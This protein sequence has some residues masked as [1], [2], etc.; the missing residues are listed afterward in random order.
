ME[1]LRIC[2]QKTWLIPNLHFGMSHWFLDVGAFCPHPA[3]P[4]QT[5]G[6]S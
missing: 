1:V 4:R 6:A 3:L 5:Q 2:E